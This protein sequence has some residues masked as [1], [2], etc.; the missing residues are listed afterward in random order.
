MLTTFRTCLLI[1]LIGLI[2]TAAAADEGRRYALLIGIGHYESTAKLQ[3]LHADNDAAQLAKELAKLGWR[4]RVMSTQGP[5]GLTPHKNN[6]LRQLGVEQTADGAITYVGDTSA[7]VTGLTAKDTLL[8]YY[9]GHGISEEGSDYLVPADATRD[10]SSALTRSSLIRLSTVHEALKRSG[11]G[12]VLLITDACRTSGAVRGGN[13]YGWRSNQLMGSS[14]DG[15]EVKLQVTP[16]TSFVELRSAS[17]AESAREADTNGVFTGHLLNLLRNAPLQLQAD[18]NKDGCVSP[19][20]MFEYVSLQTELEVE[21]KYSGSE[22]QRPTMI[23]EGTS[24]TNWHQSMCFVNCSRAEPAS[25]AGSRS[26]ITRRP[27]TVKIITGPLWGISASRPARPMSSF[28]AAYS[29]SID[30]HYVGLYDTD[31]DA[32]PRW[33][34]RDITLSAGEHRFVLEDVRVR[35]PA[36]NRRTFPSCSGTFTTTSSQ[37]VYTITYFGADDRRSIGR[38]YCEIK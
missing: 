31:A 18:K 2:P 19:A 37:A 16:D 1:V 7:F 22:R 38:E 11:A 5:G 9:A 32:R 10:A 25:T 28:T 6:V 13:P 27:D 36:G 12:R 35:A 17:N 20:E 15:K 29:L 4:T 34:E 14:P 24:A 23:T 8:V 21:Q 3:T 33:Q 30:G 26:V